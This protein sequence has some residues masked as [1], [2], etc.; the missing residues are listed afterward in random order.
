VQRAVVVALFAG[1]VG[2]DG[3]HVITISREPGC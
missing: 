3:T 2:A 1:R